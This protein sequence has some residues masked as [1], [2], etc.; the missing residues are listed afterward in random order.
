MS[1]EVEQME[2]VYNEGLVVFNAK[3]VEQKERS[4]VLLE[5]EEGILREK[6]VI[7]RL[8]DEAKE[9]ELRGEKEEAQERRKEAIR[10]RLLACGKKREEAEKEEMELR[11]EGLELENSSSGSHVKRKAEA[12][13]NGVQ[14]KKGGFGAAVGARGKSAD[15]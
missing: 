3:G 10:M 12:L 11:R 2:S 14:D 1:R 9:E 8:Q 15:Y 7:A 6:A 13:E 5:Q 4:R